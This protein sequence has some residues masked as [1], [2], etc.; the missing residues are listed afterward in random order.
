MTI[1]IMHTSEEIQY[2]RYEETLGTKD[3][4]I[5]GGYW[6]NINFLTSKKIN[7]MKLLPL[8][9]DK[10]VLKYS[11]GYDGE[12]M[13]IYHELKGKF[14]EKY[15]YYLQRFD[16]SQLTSSY[17]YNYYFYI[18]LKVILR[19]FAEEQIKI[20][21]TGPPSSGVDNLISEIANIKNIKLI[22]LYQSHN[23]RFFWTRNWSDMGYFKTSKPIFPKAK[24][25]LPEEISDP[26]Y[27]VRA[28][29]KNEKKSY[30]RERFIKIKSFCNF[31]RVYLYLIRAH[32]F[33]CIFNDK[34]KVRNTK[35]IL[36]QMY[37]LSNRI[38]SKIDQK[39]VLINN[40]KINYFKKIEVQDKS[41]ALRALFY[42]KVQ[43]EATEAFSPD[44]VTNSHVMVDQ[45]LALLPENSILYIKD[46]PDNVRNF[47]GLRRYFWETI[48]TSKKIKILDINVKT[49]EII[50]DVDVI[51]TFDGTI[52]WEGLLKNKPVITFGNPW[53]QCMPGVIPIS[54]L[55]SFDEVLD[56]KLKRSELHSRLEELS[57]SM[58]E[59]YVIDIKGGYI[60]AIDEFVSEIGL[61]VEE[62]K[63]RLE[64]NDKVVANSFMK[65]YNSIMV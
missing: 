14:F 35:E 36:L 22:C 12:I 4:I 2:S 6:K 46:H 59:G 8:S 60:N 31:F 39:S 28:K 7:L 23:G 38:S 27:M 10:E 29:E 20:I 26:F 50:D 30:N 40:S 24:I 52:G 5:F 21:F 1:L 3:R 15:C 42:L 41:V 55:I 56:L 64:S 44:F 53:Y 63:N 18:H 9:F 51:F 34:N 62:K 37:H 19:F 47:T 61:T 25:R 65:I 57:M 11:D 58:G 32:F 54:K 16:Q 43:P 33:M 13:D 17:D 45:I 49:S 48:S